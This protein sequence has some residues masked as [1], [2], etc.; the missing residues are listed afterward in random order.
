MEILIIK[1]LNDFA[2]LSPAKCAVFGL[3]T[4]TKMSDNPDCTD[5]EVPLAD[6]STKSK[7][8]QKKAAAAK[9]GGTKATKSAKE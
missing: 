1:A 6:I 3:N 4:V 7:D 9:K 5:P 2:R 8:C